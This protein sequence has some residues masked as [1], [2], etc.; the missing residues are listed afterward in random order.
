MG[1]STQEIICPRFQTSSMCLCQK[2]WPASSHIKR[3]R[4]QRRSG[5]SKPSRIS[6]LLTC[7]EF[8]QNRR[9]LVNLKVVERMPPRVNTCLLFNDSFPAMTTFCVKI[10]ARPDAQASLLDQSFF[11]CALGPANFE[12]E[13]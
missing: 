13:R 10:R 2:F 7:L 5:Q 6:Q 12:T 4:E 8:L 3:R 11:F 9:K 1:R